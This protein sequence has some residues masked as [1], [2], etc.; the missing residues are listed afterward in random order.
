MPAAPTFDLPLAQRLAALPEPGMRLV[1]LVEH[2]RHCDVVRAVWA[3]DGIVRGALK[4][5]PA[6]S[7]LF[8]SMIDPLPII[9]RL[10]AERIDELAAAAATVRGA[11]FW[12]SGCG[13]APPVDPSSDNVSLVHRDLRQVTLGKRRALAR[14]AS[15]ELLKKLLV[16]PDPVVVGNL[17]NNQHTTEATVLAICSHRP[18]IAAALEAVLASPK[19][20]LRYRVRLALVRNPA[21]PSRLGRNLLVC[22]NQADL[23]EVRADAAVSIGLRATCDDLLA[24][25]R[26]AYN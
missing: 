6:C 26:E 16:D 4:K 11:A 15:G 19:W 13:D 10:G 25:W 20:S 23:L 24:L 3:I 7:L 22:L 21:L 14:C 8:G 12:L 17:L 9:E 18:T 1:A 5:E 2:L